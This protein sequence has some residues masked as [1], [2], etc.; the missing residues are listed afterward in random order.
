MENVP[1]LIVILVVVIISM[2]ISTLV[3]RYASIET[4]K[5]VKSA[6]KF[7]IAIAIAVLTVLTAFEDVISSN[8]AYMYGLVIVYAILEG[9][10]NYREY[11]K[12]QNQQ[13]KR[14]KG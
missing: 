9:M 14:T 12:L 11:K 7:I 3:E 8:E 4:K 10:E 6:A 5:L 2:L 1:A 13:E